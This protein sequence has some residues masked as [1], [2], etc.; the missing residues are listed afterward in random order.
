MLHILQWNKITMLGAF[1]LL[2]PI[3]LLT[4]LALWLYGLRTVAVRWV[5]AV[6]MA[7]ALVMVTK[8]AYMGWGLGSVYWDYTGFSGHSLL[9]SSIYPVVFASAAVL[10][11]RP[12]AS[13]RQQRHFIGTAL[14]A[15]VLW[16]AAWMGVALALLV[17]VSRVAI[18]T[19][20][21]SEIVLGSL[22]GLAVSLS[23]LPRLRHTPGHPS[24]RRAALIIP[25]SLC[26]CMAVALMIF[27]RP[28]L[29]YVEQY[30]ALKLSGRTT[31]YT[32][33]YLHQQRQLP[34]Y[35]SETR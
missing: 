27:P 29:P 7:G 16:S 9:A 11:R 31:P 5:L 25:T 24:Y 8:V 17:A 32:R 26:A 21:I 19:H 2:M 6:G 3:T 1:E 10:W 22:L 4:A 20:S 33:D 34:P 35:R 18:N 23:I 14:T 30:V 28:Q 13:S 15:P 12:A